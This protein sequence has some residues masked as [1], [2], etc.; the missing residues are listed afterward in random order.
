MCGISLS[1]ELAYLLLPETG[2]WTAV[3]H[4]FDS[5]WQSFTLFLS[6]NSLFLIEM[7]V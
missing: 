6:R 4:W 1:V 2:S 7:I 3:F 5:A